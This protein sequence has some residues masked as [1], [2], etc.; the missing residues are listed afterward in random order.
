MGHQMSFYIVCFRCFP[1]NVC[2]CFSAFCHHLAVFFFGI[3]LVGCGVDPI[4]FIIFVY[5]QAHWK[6]SIVIFTSMSPLIALW[7]RYCSWPG[8]RVCCE[9]RHVFFILSLTWIYID[10]RH[11]HSHIRFSHKNIPRKPCFFIPTECE[12][13][14]EAMSSAME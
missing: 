11:P 1:K 12:Q 6:G 13:N 9:G 10:M 3:V 14:T 4:L 2:F 5:R 7:Y 8:N